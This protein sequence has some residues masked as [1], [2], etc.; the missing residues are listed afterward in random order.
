M[1]EDN[2][3]QLPAMQSLGRGQQ[4]KETLKNRAWW[5]LHKSMKNFTTHADDNFSFVIR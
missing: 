1:S 3:F 2:I 4:R 5:A